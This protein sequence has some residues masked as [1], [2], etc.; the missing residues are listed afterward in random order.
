MV[1]GLHTLP[2]LRELHL[3]HQQLGLGESITFD[4]RS[5]RALAVGTGQRAG[6]GLFLISPAG[7]IDR[8]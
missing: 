6:L 5:K 4:P 3:E 7:W 8:A 2:L 1:E